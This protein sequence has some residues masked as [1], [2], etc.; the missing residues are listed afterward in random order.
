M[1][2]ASRTRV[3]LVPPSA[4]SPPLHTHT[5]TCAPA[6]GR[7]PTHAG[8]HSSPRSTAHAFTKCKYNRTASRRQNTYNQNT[9]HK[10]NAKRSHPTPP[11]THTHKRTP[12]WTQTYTH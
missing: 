5:H 8:R 11:H 1:T 12:P 9:C 2:H 3:T 6:R 4:L 7:K 10:R